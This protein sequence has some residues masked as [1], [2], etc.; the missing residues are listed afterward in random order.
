MATAEN[1]WKGVGGISPTEPAR[2][3]TLAAR[4]GRRLKNSALGKKWGGFSGVVDYFF[5]REKKEPGE[6]FDHY[7][8][9][10]QKNPGNATFHLKLAEIYQR[11]GEEEKAIAKYLQSAAIF[12]RDRYFPQAMAIY[13]HILSLSPHMV[14]V[15]LKMA[16]IFRQTGF[17]ADAISQYKLAI[18]HYE[19]WG[20]REK[21]PDIKN[22]M[23]ELESQRALEEKKAQASAN[24]GELPEIKPDTNP[25]SG[26]GIAP[27]TDIPGENALLDGKEKKSDR[28]FDLRAELVS[29]EPLELKGVNEISTD[30]LFGFEEIFKELQETVIPNEVY[31]DFNYQMGL[32]CREMGFNDGAIEQLQMALEN[33]QKPIESAK[34]LS[35]CFREK[36]WFHEAE[37]YF[38]TA[39]EMENNSPKNASA[40]TQKFA[41]VH[42]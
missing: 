36:G 38:A 8:S 16:E 39:M 29:E 13:K 34:L 18:K 1:V 2:I 37:K 10:S 26:P 27:P 21:I 14:Q 25:V 22:L 40:I 33:G 30:K 23:N 7:L 35:K 4:S 12:S 6:Q 31:P 42:P 5:H 24:F 20:R 11:M 15:N 41:L 9:L 17:W 19:R 3:P 32:A 28:G